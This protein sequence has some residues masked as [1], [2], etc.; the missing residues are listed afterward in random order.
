[1]ALDS[2]SL[3]VLDKQHHIH[4]FNNPIM[5]AGGVLIAPEGYHKRIA[6]ACQLLGLIVRS[7]GYLNVLSSSLVWDKQTVDKVVSILREAIE[8]TTA[9]LLAYGFLSTENNY[10]TTLARIL[11]RTRPKQVQKYCWVQSCTLPTNPA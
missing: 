5:G 10:A 7:M 1:M 3:S 4:P 9:S 2:D 11:L 8:E 6:K